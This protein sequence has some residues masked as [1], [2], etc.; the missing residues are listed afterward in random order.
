MYAM[1]YLGCSRMFKRFIHSS[2]TVIEVAMHCQEL[3]GQFDRAMFCSCLTQHT[4]ICVSFF[5][6]QAPPHALHTLYVN[7][8]RHVIKNKKQ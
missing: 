4:H 7:F 2:K 1:S 5:F 6:F 8:M 3:I